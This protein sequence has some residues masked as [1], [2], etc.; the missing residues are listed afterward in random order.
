MQCEEDERMDDDSEH[1]DPFI[2]EGLSSSSSDDDAPLL[3]PSRNPNLQRLRTAKAQRERLKR[4][5][6]RAK[7]RRRQQRE[8]GESSSESSTD[9]SG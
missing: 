4:A 2:A 6:F 5:L 3:R 8:Q 7:D 9:S 1:E